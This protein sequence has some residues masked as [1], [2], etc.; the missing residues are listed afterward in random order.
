MS[1]EGD[2]AQAS[3]KKGLARLLAPRSLAMI[4]GADAVR[5]A[6]C[7]RAFG[8][9]GEI[10]GVNPEP[11][12]FGD[13]S[14]FER[15][16]DLPAAPDAAFLTVPPAAVL[17]AVSDLRE[18][19]TGAVVCF[20]S[21]IAASG[22][23]DASSEVAM[24][25][26]GMAFLGPAA[27]G[28]IDCRRGAALWPYGHGLS[29]A[30]RGAAIVTQS[31]S[32]AINVAIAQSGLPVASLLCVGQQAQVGVEDLV[33]L[34]ALDPDISA[35]G[36]YVEDLKH[37]DRLAAAA[38]EAAAR[39]KPVVLLRAG[40][41]GAGADVVLGH[42]GSVAG[43]EAVWD[44]FLERSGIVQVRSPAEFVE[45]LKML[46]IAGPPRRTQIAVFTLSGGDAA[47]AADLGQACGLSFPP[48]PTRARDAVSTALGEGANATNPLDLTHSLWGTSAVE[49]VVRSVLTSVDYGAALLVQD[50]PDADLRIGTDEDASD[51][52]HFA[53]AA[54]AAGVPA[55][56][57][58]TLPENLGKAA[59][60][61]IAAMG[62]AP[63]LGLADG[64]GAIAAGA[65]S[66]ELQ[67]AARVRL[68]R[69]KGRR[70]PLPRAGGTVV[71]LD[72]SAAKRRIGEAGVSVPLGVVSSLG[73]VSARAAS[74]KGPVYVKLLQ[75]GLIHKT[76]AGAVAGPFEDPQDVQAAANAIA[77][78][79]SAHERPRFLVERAIQGKVAEI[80]V[81]IRVDAR[82]GMY[83]TLGRGGVDAD[84]AP[85]RQ[86]LLIPLDTNEIALALSRLKVFPLLEGYRG[87]PAASLM[88]LCNAI[89]RLATLAACDPEV[90]FVEVNPLIATPEDAVAADALIGVYR[91][92]T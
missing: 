78:T 81:G 80:L 39:D 83:L 53:R 29:R 1:S 16:A 56:I 88:A 21:R 86:S 36:I 8:F 67:R 84:L 90:A 27:F 47:L 15:I 79:H 45:T 20:A 3:R 61:R 92:L 77:A 2:E 14:S 64:L 43:T 87:R 34:L 76:E 13:I 68:A 35:I 69:M 5:A 31:G 85:D 57:C 23:C 55:A 9:A 25:A 12:R 44:A 51:A 22:M 26:G 46:C 28:T 30:T 17:Q 10:W 41:S 54:S 4:G 42:T 63:L 33:E 91:A 71:L 7:S 72:E 6:E 24:A 73:E 75:S 52:F 60:Q 50:V 66:A 74:L 19:G 65:R 58:A 32:I 40:R 18:L 49:D 70:G 89:D 48:P 59:R 11:S 37:P 38:M 62:V 82:F